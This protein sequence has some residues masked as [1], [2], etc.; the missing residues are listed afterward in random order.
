MSD[1]AAEQPASRA[2]ATCASSR[3]RV[4][5]AAFHAVRFARSPAADAIRTTAASARFSR[6]LVGISS[7]ASKIDHAAAG[8]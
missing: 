1:P 4:R 5:P 8:R 3:S 2:R 7:E 6:E